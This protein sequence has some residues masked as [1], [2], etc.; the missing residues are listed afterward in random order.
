MKIFL[1]HNEG[2]GSAGETE[3][4][5]NLTVEN[6]FLKQFPN[7]AYASRCA[8]LTGPSRCDVLIRVNREEQSSTYILQA[9]DRVTVTRKWKS[10]AS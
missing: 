4:E 6:F 2:A 9:G 7:S 3:I 10:K 5:E 8:G 1:T